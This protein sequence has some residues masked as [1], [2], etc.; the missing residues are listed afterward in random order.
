MFKPIRARLAGA[1]ILC[2]GVIGMAP[3][4]A[5]AYANNYC[6]E[7]TRTVYIGGRA[8][9]AYGTACLQPNGDWMITGEGLG[10]DIPNNVSDVQYVIRDNT[11]YIT[12]TRVVHYERNY[13]RSPHVQPSFI[14]YH[15]GHYKNGHYVKYKKKKWD[16][17]YHR[18]WDRHDHRGHG[19]R[20]HGHHHGHGRD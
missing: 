13:Y 5:Q 19:H 17:H 20:H 16:R 4:D 8:Q 12:P 1:A 9:E 14:W 15:N 2:L 18:R 11:R 7:Y 3:S 6:R 10:N